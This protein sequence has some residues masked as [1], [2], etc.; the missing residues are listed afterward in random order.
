LQLLHGRQCGIRGD[1]RKHAFGIVD[2]PFGE[3]FDHRRL[4]VEVV[5][6]G[7]LGDLQVLEDVLNSQALIAIGQDQPLRGVQNRIAPSGLFGNVDGPGHH[8]S[9]Y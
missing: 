2:Q 8:P 5:I 6:E 9:H 3:G 7:A 1:R 4:G